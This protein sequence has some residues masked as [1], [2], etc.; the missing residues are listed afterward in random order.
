M[1]VYVQRGGGAVVGVYANP[2]PGIA[3][4]AVSDDAP[5]VVA[6]RN[7]AAKTVRELAAL[8]LGLS[9]P[10]AR[11]IRAAVL[12]MMDELNVL[13]QRDRDRATDVAA[14]TSL[15]DLK[16]RWALRPGLADR[17]AGQMRPNLVA[18]VST[19]DAD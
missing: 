19:P 2:Q 14:A 7:P 18:R 11:A 8:L 4:E 5:E 16:T 9:D 3:E 6:F 12:L 15:A 17:N 10:V 13:R 1:I